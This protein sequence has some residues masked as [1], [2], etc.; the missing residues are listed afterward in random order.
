[1]PHGRGSASYLAV[2]LAAVPSGC[3]DGPNLP[4]VSADRAAQPVR[5]GSLTLRVNEFTGSDQGNAS[6]AAGPGGRILVA[7]DSRRQDDASPGVY[8]RFV[9]AAGEALTPEVRVNTCSPGAQLGPAAAVDPRGR[10]WI[11]WTSYGQDGEAGGIVARRL[12]HDLSAGTSEIPVNATREGNQHAPTI[13][14]AGDGHVLIAW[15]DQAG[16]GRRIIAARV[17]GP[18]ARPATSE[19]RI[20][21]G[22]GHDAAP[23]AAADPGGGFVV[24]WARADAHGRPREIVVRRLDPGGSPDGD[25]VVIDADGGLEPV[26]AADGTDVLAGWMFADGEGFGVRARWL[27]G[28]D[29]PG[30]P[31]IT[32]AEPRDGSC[33]GAAAALG[34]GGRGLIAFHRAEPAGVTR[35]RIAELSHDADSSR[36]AGLPLAG[37]GPQRLGGW[38]GAPRLA[39]LEGGAVAVAWGG[40]AGLH[41]ASAAH[42][43]IME[44]G[45]TEAP[46]PARLPAL[47][48]VEVA[49]R[50]VMPGPEHV[51]PTWDIHWRGPTP[52]VGSAGDGPDFGFEGIPM[53][54]WVPPDPEMAVGP[55]HIVLIANGQIAFFD[56]NGQNTFRQQ[57]GPNG[58]WGATGAGAM[59]F[60]P[61]VQYD[62]WSDRFWALAAERNAGS[63]FLLAVSDDG[64]P[65]GTWFKHRIDVTSLGGGGDIDSPNLAMD[66]DALYLSADFFSGGDKHLVYVI[67]KSALVNGSPA[68][69]GA[70]L[71]I[72]GTRSLGSAQSFDPASPAH[73]LVESDAAATGTKVTLHAIR[74]AP[75]AP[76]HDTFAVSVPAYQF[77]GTPPQQG[78]S[79]TMTLFEPRF[80]SCTHRHGSVWATHHVRTASSGGRTIVRWYEFDL[81]GWPASGQTPILAQWG[82][83]DPGP[84]LHAYFPSIG[85]DVQGNAAITYARS[86]TGEFISMWRSARR[87]NDPPG[88]MRPAELVKASQGPFSSYARWGDYSA[89]R[90]DPARPCALWGHHEFTYGGNAWRTWVARYDLY[91]AADLNHDCELTIADFGAF[92]SLFVAGNVAADFNGDGLLTIADFAAFQ[93]AFVAGR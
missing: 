90:P 55:G 15:C 25:E 73:Y 72:G 24:A 85:V 6:V 7:W 30:S 52:P 88:S 76:T 4:P 31:T 59:V 35:V 38:T 11:A 12:E 46:A 23:C 3:V 45:A 13:A 91:A 18:D 75:S 64:D 10:A 74:G 41:D 81:R 9:D 32:L 16:A 51:P 86:G 77:P 71:L 1:M 5:E 69:A 47:A 56:K 62:A 49:M 17:Y 42:L 93:T 58:F 43:T 28:R 48:Y 70:S 27:S 29:R 36:C 21:Q 2:T 57:L 22:T 20:D 68:P 50:S 82:E 8:A 83:I 84:T 34:P 79:V 80:W 53:T 61:E 26:I 63:Y 89:T 54:G 78:S 33:G 60:D 44:P 40:D 19:L 87:W 66:A 67:P 65:N 92:Q 37:A 14:I 39:T